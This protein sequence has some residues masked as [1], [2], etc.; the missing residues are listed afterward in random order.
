M[1]KRMRA[2]VQRVARSEVS[3]G[4]RA[5]GRIGAGLNVL[6]GIGLGDTERDAEWL[7]GKILG[8]R[9]F[10]DS[11][12]KMNL[13]VRDVAGELLVVSQ[14]TLYGDCAKGNRPSF[15]AAMPQE[16]AK[17]LYDKFVAACGGG[18]VRVETGEFRADMKVLI[19]NDGPVTLIIDSKKP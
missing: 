9:V 15:A 1:V 16:A 18:G 2:V 5:R 7:A 13:S 11:G 10:E 8:L 4:G 17:G 12:G 14:F 6:V 19:E 3:V